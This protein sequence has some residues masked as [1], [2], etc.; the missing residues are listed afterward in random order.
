MTSC[1][2]QN[3]YDIAFL[4]PLVA[5]FFHGIFENI[6]KPVGAFLEKVDEYMVVY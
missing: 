5:I 1:C 2:R 6:S 3:V 4:L